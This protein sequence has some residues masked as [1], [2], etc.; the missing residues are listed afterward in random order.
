MRST[1]RPDSIRAAL[2]L[3]RVLQLEG[4]TAEAEQ[5]AARAATMRPDHPATIGSLLIGQ[6][7]PVEAEQQ[8][9]LALE[10]SPDHP[11]VRTNLG[12]ALFRQGK[13]EQAI[14][15]YNRVLARS[16]LRRRPRLPRRGTARQGRHIRRPRPS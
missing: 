5:L 14:A 13:A 4:R 16:E 12:L 7:R 11:L 2:E 3:G 8:L 6:G 9:R 15:E 10:L 1:K